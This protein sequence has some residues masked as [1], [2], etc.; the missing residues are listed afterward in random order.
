MRRTRHDGWEKS[1]PGT[2][3]PALCP[4]HRGHP[5]ALLSRQ[6]NGAALN[7]AGCKGGRGQSWGWDQR[8]SGDFLHSAKNARL[9]TPIGHG[10]YPYWG[11]RGSVRM[12]VAQHIEDKG[13]LDPD[14]A[15]KG[16]LMAPDG[17]RAEV[18]AG[19]DL[20]STGVWWLC[21]SQVLGQL[22]VFLS[23]ALNLLSACVWAEVSYKVR[24]MC[25]I[26]VCP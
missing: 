8:A 19:D 22:P 16:K 2:H 17:I 3:A 10:S 11:R 18:G 7:G 1:P 6:H 21:A 13:V 14:R 23:C 4:C 15:G 26:H 20:A 24:W 25:S 12:T 5:L 9:P